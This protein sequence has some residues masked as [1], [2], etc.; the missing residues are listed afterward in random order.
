[1]NSSKLCHDVMI[2]I[3]LPKMATQPIEMLGYRIMYDNN[4]VC[5]TLLKQEY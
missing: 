4:I 5:V 2:Y 3:T 1:M